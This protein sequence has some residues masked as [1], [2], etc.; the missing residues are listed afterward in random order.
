MVKPF[1]SGD[2]MELAGTL[3][4]FTPDEEAL[5]EMG[6]CFVEEFARMGWKG[7]A[8]LVVFRNPFYRG[9]HAVYRAL[10]EDYVRALV[11]QIAS[12]VR[13]GRKGAND[14]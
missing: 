4:P 6:R 11:E 12:P 5:A 8:V 1:E 13:G 10:G 2:P 7:P 14:A 9:P 3:L